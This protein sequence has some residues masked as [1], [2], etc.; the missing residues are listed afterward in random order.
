MRKMASDW[1]IMDDKGVICDG[2]YEEIIDIWCNEN[3]D[4]GTKIKGNL[5][6]VKICGRR[7]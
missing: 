3:Y 1:A 5:L 7:H 6:L 4:Y 2:S